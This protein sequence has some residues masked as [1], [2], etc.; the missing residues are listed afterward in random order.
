M[1]SARF[2]VTLKEHMRASFTAV[3]EEPQNPLLRSF[4]FRHNHVATNGWSTFIGAVINFSPAQAQNAQFG[5]AGQATLEGFQCRN[6]SNSVRHPP[7][8][9]FYHTGNLA[10]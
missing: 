9:W 8:L 4:S 2:G 10:P 7:C 3:N 6:A 1:S 5:A